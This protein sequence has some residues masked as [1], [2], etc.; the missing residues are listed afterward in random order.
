M[1]KKSKN[2]YKDPNRKGNEMQFIEVPTNVL[3]SR[4]RKAY[5]EAYK[6]TGD[7]FFSLVK[8]LEII[9]KSSKK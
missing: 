3:G 1:P 5:N 9:S 2:F 4:R 8:S 6:R 7:T